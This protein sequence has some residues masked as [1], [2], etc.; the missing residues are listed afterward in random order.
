MGD[1]VAR[2]H[3]RPLGACALAGTGLVGLGALLSVIVAD[4]PGALFAVVAFLILGASVLVERWLFFTEAEHV[5][6]P[7]CGASRA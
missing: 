2:T 1:P 5:E 4:P 7:F 3:A 6:T